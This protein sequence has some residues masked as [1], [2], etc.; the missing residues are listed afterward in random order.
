MNI[1]SLSIHRLL[2]LP[3]TPNDATQVVMISSCDGHVC[4]FVSGAVSLV[5][6]GT[7]L[8]QF[9]KRFP[10]RTGLELSAH[11]LLTQRNVMLD[12]SF[13]LGQR[14]TSL[15]VADHLFMWGEANKHEKNDI[16]NWG[17]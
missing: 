5:D 17:I 14:F 15:D 10:H 1:L 9:E 13:G 8:Q 11:Q 12:Q 3:Y 7:G 16:D 6:V 4:V 2:L